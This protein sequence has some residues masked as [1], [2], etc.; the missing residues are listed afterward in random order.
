MII[1]N[2]NY[3]DEEQLNMYSKLAHDVGFL[4]LFVPFFKTR[5]LVE[6]CSLRN[7]GFVCTMLKIGQM[8]MVHIHVIMVVMSV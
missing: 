1:N 3:M 5:N 6:S 4:G 8:L 2:F 7:D